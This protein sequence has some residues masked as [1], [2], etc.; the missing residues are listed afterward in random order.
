MSPGSDVERRPARRTS[1]HLS[2]L[3]DDFDEGHTF[4]ATDAERVAVLLQHLELRRP[5]RNPFV[6]LAAPS[7]TTAADGLPYLHGSL[8]VRLLLSEDH[9]RLFVRVA[10]NPSGRVFDIEEFVSRAEAI[11]QKTYRPNPIQEDSELFEAPPPMSLLDGALFGGSKPGASPSTSSP[12]S[13]LFG[14]SA[15]SDK[16]TP[17]AVQTPLRSLLGG[18]GAVAMEKP[19]PNTSSQP[20]KELFKSHWSAR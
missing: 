20:W 10:G 19:A 7:G 17:S 13:S 16:G 14:G 3:S 2:H 12:P 6:A 11:E 5:L 1:S 9:Q 8:E 18:P 4:P 15:L